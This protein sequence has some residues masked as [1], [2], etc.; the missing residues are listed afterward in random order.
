[1]PDGRLKTLAA[2]LVA[3]ACLAAAAADSPLPDIK[4]AYGPLGY[5]PTEAESPSRRL[6][7]GLIATG[8]CTLAFYWIIRRRRRRKR[9]MQARPPAS[10]PLPDESLL[11]REPGDFYACLT[12]VL[13][14]ALAEAG[15][16]AALARTPREMI[17]SSPTAARYETDDWEAFWRRAEA[18][19]YA[20]A[21]PTEEERRIDLAFVTELVKQLRSPRARGGEPDAV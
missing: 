5:E 9:Q 4:D 17:A 10:A 21:P 7:A 11:E 15:E 12:K 18:A 2:T 19:E 14:R 20:A 6:P 8:F 3:A 13:R 1:M 16:A